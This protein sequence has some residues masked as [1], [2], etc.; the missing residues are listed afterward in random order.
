LGEKWRDQE[1]KKFAGEFEK[2]KGS[3]EQFIR[4]AD[5]HVSHLQKKARSLDR[6]FQS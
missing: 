4:I 5:E 1:R 2:T 6:Y 3:L